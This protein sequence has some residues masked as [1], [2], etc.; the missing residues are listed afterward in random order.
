MHILFLAYYHPRYMEPLK[1]WGGLFRRKGWTVK[2]MYPDAFYKED[3]LEELENDHDLIIYFGHGIP[4]A[5]SGFGT[6]SADDI[7]KIKSKSN[8]RV[9]ISLSCG[10]LSSMNGKN[11]AEAFIRNY[12]ALY[13]VGYKGRIRYKENLDVVNQVFS[14]LLDSEELK[15]DFL[16]SQ[17]N[18]LNN[19]QLH[20]MSNRDSRY[21][22]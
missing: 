11:I 2:E 1:Y 10:S 12:L 15:I 17:I 14:W 19:I 20:I 21:I 6:I 8:K 3:V 13:V 5:W 9:I 16:V 18:D 4:G 22:Y 7:A